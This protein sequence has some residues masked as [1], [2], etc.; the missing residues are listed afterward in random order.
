MQPVYFKELIDVSD[1]KKGIAIITLWT[2]KEKVLSQLSEP[3]S[4]IGQLYSKDEGINAIIRNLLANKDIR[5]L[6]ITGID[7]TKSGEYLIK[8][9]TEGVD[10]E[11]KITGTE[12]SIDKEIPAVALE[13]LRCNVIVYDKR[14]IHDLSELNKL[15]RSL[16]ESKPY[17]EAEIFPEKIFRQPDVYPTDPM[18]FKIRKKFISDAWREILSLLMRFGYVKKSR[19]SD[20]I[21]ELIN[22]C[23][24][25]IDEDADK[26]KIPEYMLFNKQALDA[27]I[28]KITTPEKFPDISYTYGQRLRDYNSIDQ[29]KYII[30]DLKKSSYSRAAIAFTWCVEK[31]TKETHSPCMNMVHVLIQDKLH[32]TSYIRSNDMFNAWPLNAFGLRKLQKIIADEAGFTMGT[33]TTISGS[34]HIYSNDFLKAEKILKENPVIHDMTGDPRGNFLIVVENRKIKVTHQSPDGKSIESFYGE[35]AEELCKKMELEFRVS[36]ISH[37]LYVG[38]EL[39]KAETALKAGKQYVQDKK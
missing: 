6:I 30:D 9:F 3:Y 22:V 38:S 16:P 2:P 5:H 31:D 13:N 34:S 4:A 27:Y 33:L 18:V 36:Q 1:S 10:R 28:P 26:P 15:I 25:I 37:A 24:I 20:D 14:G 23:A 11:N 8:F 35:T 7:I 29:I 32:M 12:I 21:K 17:G 19:Y 39:Q